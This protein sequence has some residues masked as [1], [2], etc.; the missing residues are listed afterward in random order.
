MKQTSIEEN[1]TRIFGTKKYAL[2]LNPNFGLSNDY[3]D[4][5]LALEAKSNL[6]KEIREQIELFEPRIKIENIAISQENSKLIISINTDIKV[7]L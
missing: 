6:I 7:S 1:L 4:K 3:I 5:P 2:P